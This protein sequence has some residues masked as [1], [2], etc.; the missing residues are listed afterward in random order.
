MPTKSCRHMIWWWHF[1]LT[2]TFARFS[3]SLS[4]YIYKIISTSYQD[5]KSII[6]ETNTII[7]THTLKLY[8]YLIKN[9]RIIRVNKKNSPV[10]DFIL[11][12]PSVSPSLDSL[13]P[14]PIYKIN[15]INVTL[16]K[17]KFTT[18]HTRVYIYITIIII[19]YYPHS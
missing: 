7:I 15:I 10:L 14:N 12:Q 13:M 4:P 6:Y 16:F 3:I 17:K 1:H 8:F 18:T 9:H 2:T 19:Q 5:I 11:V